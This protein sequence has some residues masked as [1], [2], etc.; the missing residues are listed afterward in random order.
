MLVNSSILA[1]ATQPRC[2]ERQR[3]VVLVACETRQSCAI[4]RY[5]CWQV[6]LRRVLE[7]LQVAQFG[8]L[9]CRGGFA[10][11][12]W[13]QVNRGIDQRHQRCPQLIQGLV[14]LAVDQQLLGLDAVLI[15]V[16]HTDEATDNRH[17][18]QRNFQ[19]VEN[20]AAPDRVVFQPQLVV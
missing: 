12:A 2:G 20:H 5:T 8:E 9:A 4:D 10:C 6:D 19:V 1:F 13:Q 11:N 14:G 3:F 16:V 7:V 15:E 17:Q 18:A